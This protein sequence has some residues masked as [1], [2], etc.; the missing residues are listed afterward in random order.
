MS[1]T[2]CQT[3]ITSR[4]SSTATLDATPAMA[5]KVRANVTPSATP[6][7]PAKNALPLPRVAIAHDT[8]ITETPT[9]TP[10]VQAAPATPPPNEQRNSN[11]GYR[12][13]HMAVA[14]GK[15]GVT[16]SPS[17]EAR[18][19][20]KRG[21]GKPLP[22]ATKSFMEER[23]GNDFSQVRIHT[24]HTAVQLSQ[25]LQA[26]AFTHGHDI[27]FNSGQY[28]PSST[29]GKRLLAHELTH[30]I[31]QKGPRLKYTV[32]QM[33]VNQEVRKM[34]GKLLA[35]RIQRQEEYQ[36][37]DVN[38]KP[39]ASGIARI[40]LEEIQPDLMVGA[41]GDR[42]ER[43]ADRIADQVITFTDIPPS[44]LTPQ[45]SSSIDI[46][47]QPLA[48]TLQRGNG[49]PTARRPKVIPYG[50]L[51]NANQED[52]DERNVNIT[53]KREDASSD[54][55]FPASESIE[56]KIKSHEGGGN[57]LP[58]DTKTFMESRFNHDFSEVRVH[59]DSDAVH[60]NKDLDAKAF[61]HK[62]DIYFNSGQYHPSSQTGKHL[63]AH[64]LTHTIQQTGPNVK[65][66]LEIQREEE[67]G[68]AED[69][70]TEE[71]MP[72]E[73]L[74]KM[75]DE[76]DTTEAEVE[77]EKEGEEKTEGSE[78][79]EEEEEEEEGAEKITAEGKSAEM[80]LG[81]E[82]QQGLGT[83][84]EEEPIAIAV[85]EVSSDQ[86]DFTDPRR[87]PA[88]AAV[89]EQIRQ[90][91]QQ[92]AKHDP[93]KQEAAEVQEAVVDP[94]KQERDA[95][96]TKTDTASSLN[97]E[98]FDREAFVQKLFAALGIEEPKKMA[99]MESG[100]G[101]GAQTE[102]TAKEE[103]NTA[104][105]DAGGGIPE[106][107]AL[108][109]D[110]TVEEPKEV[111]EM[112]SLESKT[113]VEETPVEAD[114]AVPPVAAEEDIEEPLQEQT[115]ALE[116]TFGPIQTQLIVGGAADQYEQEADQMAD[117][118][119]QMSDSGAEDEQESMQRQLHPGLMQAKSLAGMIGRSRSNSAGGSPTWILQRKNEVES[120]EIGQPDP[121]V[122]LN[123][124]R[125]ETWGEVGGDAAIESLQAS[126]KFSQE[127]PKQ[128][129]IQEQTAISE[130]KTRNTEQSQQTHETMEGDRTAIMQEVIAQKQ[131]TKT[132]NE[133]VRQQVTTQLNQIYEASQ[134]KVNGILA[135][136][137][138]E[139]QRRMNQGLALARRAFEMV[140]KEAFK[141]WQKNYYY[142]RHGIK[143]RFF[144]KTW[145]IFNFV[146][147]AKEKLFTGLP[148]EVNRIYTD[149]REV[150]VAFLRQSISG[151]ATFPPN[152]QTDEVKSVVKGVDKLFTQL[153]P[154]APYVEQKMIE[155]KAAIDEGK[156]QLKSAVDALSPE[157]KQLAQG[158]IGEIENQFNTLES[159]VKNHQDNLVNNIVE[160]YQQGLDDIDSRIEELKSAN[161]GLVKKALAA[162]G[163]L[164]KE[165]LKILVFP[166]K[167]I[168]ARFG[169][170][171]KIIDAIIDDPGGFMKNF[172][173]GLGDGFKNF[174]KNFDK[175]F[176]NGLVEWL[177]GNL[178]PIKL[179]KKFDLQGFFDIFM[180]VMGFTVDAIFDVAG[181]IFGYDLVGAIRQLI[182]GA[183][184]QDVI[185]GMDPK[186]AIIFEMFY[187]LIKKGVV[188]AWSF[189]GDAIAEMKDMFIKEITITV[190][191]EVVKAAIFWLLGIL[192]PA[193]GI[194][195]IVKA[196]VDVIVWFKDNYESI[197]QL[198][199][200]IFDGL[201]AVARGDTALMSQSVEATLARMIPI[202]LGFMIS[203][204]GL[205]GIF[206]KIRA[207][208]EKVAGFFRAQL[209]KMFNKVV[210]PIKARWEKMKAKAK[211]KYESAKASV[212]E[213]Y[214]SAKATV[215]E[216]YESAKAAVKEKVYDAKQTAKGALGMKQETPAEKK[217]RE[218]KET[219]YKQ[220]L[221]QQ[222]TEV[223]QMVSEGER[224][225][226]KLIKTRRDPE[227]VK[228]GLPSLE[229][230]VEEG[231]EYANVTGVK[232]KKPLLSWSKYTVEGS[233]T[234]TKIQRQP[235]E[236]NSRIV[237]TQFP[238][239]RV[240]RKK[241]K[242]LDKKNKLI[243]KEDSSS[244]KFS[245]EAKLID[246][247]DV[248]RNL[249]KDIEKRVRRDYD[250]EDVKLYLP[251]WKKEYDLA[252]ITFKNKTGLFDKLDREIEYDIIAVAPK[253][254]ETT[255]SR[256]AEPGLSMA[257]V[258][259]NVEEAI[260]RSQGKGEPL[261]TPVRA[262]M[263]QAFGVDFTGV[264]IHRH[265]EGD[266]LSRALNAKAFTTGQNI[267]FRHHT[268]RPHTPSGN[269]LLA[270]ELT[271]V[272]QQ[273]GYQ[274]QIQRSPLFPQPLLQRQGDSPP[275]K[276][277]FSH[278]PRPTLIQRNPEEGSSIDLGQ[279]ALVTGAVAMTTT[280]S[281]MQNN[282]ASDSRLRTDVDVFHDIDRQKK[283]LTVYVKIKRSKLAAQQQQKMAVAANKAEG[284]PE[285]TR[286]LIGKHIET[287]VR[288]DPTLAAVEKK[289]PEVTLKFDLDQVRVI[290]YTE[291]GAS[292]E[293]KILAQGNPQA[294]ALKKIEDMLKQMAKMS[295]PNAKIPTP[296]EEEKP[297]AVPEETPEPETK[298]SEDKT[299]SN[300][301]TSEGE[302][303][304][305]PD[306]KT[307]TSETPKSAEK[308]KT[309]K[310]PTA[311]SD[312][313]AVPQT[314][315]AKTQI[316][317][318]G[319]PK[320]LFVTVRVDPEEVG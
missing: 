73:E 271:H 139:V 287:I 247:S 182:E 244:T 75:K 135:E 83:Q 202:A 54:G 213:K 193:A 165:I 190:S 93:P 142:H 266:R 37:I 163:D 249:A 269:H 225:G 252:S 191:V 8:L 108:P 288:Q 205:G 95:K 318:G 192:N 62:Q 265:T 70:L 256:T 26:K 106:A 159:N 97:P 41:P 317:P 25:D 151:N 296:Q 111:T 98:T 96:E 17:V 68:Q 128:F 201:S 59:T 136:M 217:E 239:Q 281:M 234:K 292:F 200:T 307:T 82:L 206:N 299:D 91:S 34:R 154:I 313:P 27:Y 117:R 293:Y 305:E 71:D 78:A 237:L 226:E 279:M 145:K 31:Q 123:T 314:L 173:K 291:I 104:K 49:K 6:S 262:P 162:I 186:I 42:Y 248:L 170:D 233:I 243:I 116:D 185:Q 46:N 155:A 109:P 126:K 121:E 172:F 219:A 240:Q 86:G 203:L 169:V 72:E 1:L 197:K 29:A 166:L 300:T 280:A 263:E 134:T 77:E 253:D 308:T 171:T 133:E 30:T 210:A 156:A 150:Y 132:Q 176:L 153:Q 101:I 102:G 124:E 208:I 283:E 242:W 275:P 3:R 79:E 180:Q 232:L 214:E 94:H 196:V 199:Q 144:G 216:K 118:V 188:A 61:T 270:H 105:T 320:T 238:F 114:K 122:S 5:T 38:L 130:T 183:N 57:T 11:L 157:E 115:E 14:P 267:F 2:L 268:Y 48:H 21:K 309:A 28:N 181:K 87:N 175:H 129:R 60:M 100:G 44:P 235:M 168:L 218:A 189:L 146:L 251:R 211:E 250:P 254:E 160:N 261:P 16:A 298:P 52:E 112:P 88:V 85:P 32:A 310:V 215:K 125:M 286:T 304:T 127:Q 152:L 18:I 103:V 74:E 10:T 297:T 158:A 302:N 221:T 204:I 227:E 277:L 164:L 81:A 53:L 276:P 294:V 113:Q 241:N 36:G 260:G 13:G 223:K 50:A 179:P 24:D 272:V 76:A 99:E 58:E 33:K 222:K 257:P 66:K 89:T 35:Q 312:A 315:S 12:F 147:W 194:V 47:L 167:A 23:F 228:K 212:K 278:F 51:F 39:L 246:E 230:A 140:Q 64:E 224:E 187:T 255:A 195:K 282:S 231:K 107:T 110:P 40:R 15:G 80:D 149:A 306:P 178:G 245:V 4:R 295:T 92:F 311:Q 258:P 316:K 131:D 84:S 141:K 174:S 184:L 65:T 19:Q 161:E 119:M 67:E 120:Q 20:A 290:G 264:R 220:K 209:E 236:G 90:R 137:D 319:D 55:S 259:G 69:V 22:A 9:E 285:F 56:T 301:R 138:A 274:P 273:A 45:A 148:D 284:I 7:A 177:F 303:T 198:V 207:K 143:I 63:L 229:S 43:E 289:L